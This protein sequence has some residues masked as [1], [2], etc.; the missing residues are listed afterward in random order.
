MLEEYG[1]LP[2]YTLLD[3]TVTLDVGAELDRPGHPGVPDAS[4][5][6]F[7]RGS[8]QAL[9]EFAPGA[10]FY[11]RGWEIADRRRRPRRRRRVAIRPWA[12]CPACGFARR[13]RRRRVGTPIAACPRCGEHRH[14]R[15]RPAA[16]RRRADPGLRRGAPRRGG[17]LRPAR[18]ARPRRRSSI[19][20]AAD[21][22]PASVA[23]QWFVEDYGF[24][25]STCA[26]M[27]LRWLNIG[28]RRATACTRIIAGDERTGAAVPGLRGLRQA[29]HRHRPQP[30]ARAPAPGARYRE[31]GRGAHRRTS[32]CPGPCAPRGCCSGCRTRSPSATTS[33][34]PAWPRRCC[35]GCASRSAGTPTTSQV[36]HVVDPTLSRR[37]RQPRRAAAAR[38][39]AR[40][41]RLP[42]RARR[43]RHACATCW[44]GLASGCAT[45]SAGTRNGWPA[46]AA[47]CR[48]PRPSRLR[49][50]SR[51][52]AER[53]L[54]ATCSACPRTPTRA[55]SA[56]GPAWTADADPAAGSPESHL[57]QTLPQVDR[58]SG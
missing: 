23:R 26:R 33:P 49:R 4:T 50:V 57:E 16:R 32:R 17:D 6:Q 3:D 8:A 43:P 20:T 11:A 58:R 56:D 40:R 41:H 52:A 42:G 12:F 9:R 38:R 36:E 7:Q 5:R 44:P 25:A 45:A 18:R 53:H 35:S 22:D 51:A 14:R 19:V 15:H 39:R 21:I 34:C 47:C 28:R 24:G 1:I 27:D 31:G 54:R 37:H 10:T 55:D 46:T 30:P 13:H 29:R 48:S 2:N